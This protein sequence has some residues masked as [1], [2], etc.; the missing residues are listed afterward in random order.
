MLHDSKTLDSVSYG[1]F[2]TAFK[3]KIARC[4]AQI[5]TR[6]ISRNLAKLLG[7]GGVLRGPSRRGFQAKIGN[8]AKVA[9]LAPSHSFLCLLKKA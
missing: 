2:R 6:E 5:F 3:K 1:I 7:R 8:S 9:G 4:G